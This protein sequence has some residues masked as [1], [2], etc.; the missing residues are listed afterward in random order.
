MLAAVAAECASIHM[1]YE[2]RQCTEEDRAWA[3]ALKSE[4]YREVVERQFG[5]WDD[6]KQ[7]E[8]FAARWDPA[9][10]RIVVVDGVAV[11][12]V[13]V[14][15]RSEELWLD[16]IQLAS[17]WRGRGIG[18]AI[19]RDLVSRAR[20]ERKALRLRVLRENALAQKLYHRLGF[21]VVGETATHWLVEHGDAPGRPPNPALEPLAGQR[22]SVHPNHH[23]ETS[24]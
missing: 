7:R 12:L 23:N 9:K 15:D 16:E 21:R 5:P 8:Q 14:Q 6:G 1:R 10:S 24:H 22:P 4:A 20:A 11:G 13:A 3:Y 19:L 17:G 2:F 18:T